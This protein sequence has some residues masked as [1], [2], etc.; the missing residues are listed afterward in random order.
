MKSSVLVTRLLIVLAVSVIAG[1]YLMVKCM[2]SFDIGNLPYA[3]VW[4]CMAAGAI[5]VI[6]ICIAHLSDIR[7]RAGR[8][9]DLDHNR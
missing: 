6:A 3:V 7:N 8:Y 5:C 1:T 9:A 2:V 4:G